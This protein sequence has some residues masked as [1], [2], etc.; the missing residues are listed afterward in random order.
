MKKITIL[1]I[2]L[3]GFMFSQ[4]FDL[5]KMQS[6]I[7]KTPAE[8]ALAYNTK[9]ENVKDNFGDEKI[10]FEKVKINDSNYLLQV[11]TSNKTI[12]EITIAA[13]ENTTNFFKINAEYL[14]SIS[15]DPE[16]KDLFISVTRKINGKK[17]YFNTVNELILNL[18]D[19]SYSLDYYSANVNNY[20]SKMNLI[21]SKD[22]SFIV[23]E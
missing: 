20:S 4:T 5:K 14:E 7:N 21:L 3:S 13:L 18:K 2:L 15:T 1:F 19:G 6:F 12:K 23:I 9:I 8:F 22:L 10:S 16:K 17:S 11:S